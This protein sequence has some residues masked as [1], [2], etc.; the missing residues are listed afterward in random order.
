MMVQQDQSGNVESSSNNTGPT[1][2]AVVTT[3][4]TL[5]RDVTLQQFDGPPPAGEKIQQ[6]LEPGSL[7]EISEDVM[8][9]VWG[10]KT[11]DRIIA[12]VLVYVPPQYHSDSEAGQ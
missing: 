9:T 4:T 1:V 8:V 11:G 7:D 5:H 3:Q 12:D 2:E 10:K 6:V